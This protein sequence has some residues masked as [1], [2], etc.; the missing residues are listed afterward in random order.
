MYQK[1]IY[2][3]GG[4]IWGHSHW[5]EVMPSSMQSVEKISPYAN[6]QVSKTNF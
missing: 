2:L 6:S 4:G 1:H 3:Q 5:L